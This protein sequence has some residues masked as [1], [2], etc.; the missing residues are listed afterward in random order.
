MS[1][2]LGKLLYILDLFDN[3]NNFNAIDNMFIGTITNGSW[4]IIEDI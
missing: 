4:L 1:L 2:M 3:S